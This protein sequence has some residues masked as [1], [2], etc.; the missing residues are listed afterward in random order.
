MNPLPG[1]EFGVSGLHMS[2]LTHGRVRHVMNSLRVAPG[3]HSSPGLKAMG[4]SGRYY[5]KENMHDMHFIISFSVII[6]H[7]NIS[8]KLLLKTS[9]IYMIGIACSLHA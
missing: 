1:L 9:F 4:F 8:P 2:D 6:S 3:G 7:E 5:I